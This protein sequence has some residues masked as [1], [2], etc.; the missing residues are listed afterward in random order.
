MVLYTVRLEDEVFGV[1]EDLLDTTDQKLAYITLGAVREL[2]ATKNVNYTR[3]I[4]CERIVENEY[5]WW[6]IDSFKSKFLNMVLNY[7]KDNYN[8]K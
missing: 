5:T 8:R 7:V 4:I 2:Y 3:A 1:H 6:Y